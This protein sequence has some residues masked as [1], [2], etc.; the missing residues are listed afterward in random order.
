MFI[1]PEPACGISVGVTKK[2]VRDWTNRG[3]RKHWDSL[4]GQKQKKA[5]IQGNLSK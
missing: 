1:R 5:L 4:R 2:A 3:H